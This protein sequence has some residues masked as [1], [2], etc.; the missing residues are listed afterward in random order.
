[1]ENNPASNNVATVPAKKLRFFGLGK[2]R[3]Y[4]RRHKG[5]FAVM[6][7]S[8]IIVGVCN[9]IVPLFQRYAIDNFILGGTLDGLA[10][11]IA[12]YVAMLVA[13]FV[14]DFFGTYGCSRLELFILRDMR[15]LAF[16]K[17][18]TLSVLA[19]KHI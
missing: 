16:N 7:I 13:M 10:P 15:G 3:P 18:Q 12:T 8:N 9:I 17:L 11:F 2:L 5:L 19:L 1:M 4:A 6:I 14:I